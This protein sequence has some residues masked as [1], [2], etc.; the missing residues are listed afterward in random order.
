[1]Q[2]DAETV[3]IKYEPQFSGCTILGLLCHYIFIDKP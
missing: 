3:L 2:K 1:M